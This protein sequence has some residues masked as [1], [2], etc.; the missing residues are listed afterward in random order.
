MAI[1]RRGF[2]TAL[3]LVAFVVAWTVREFQPSDDAPFAVKTSPSL[4][5][6]IVASPPRHDRHRHDAIWPNR[7]AASYFAWSSSRIPPSDAMIPLVS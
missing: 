5:R 3:V 7:T 1:R 6:K 2:A 4:E